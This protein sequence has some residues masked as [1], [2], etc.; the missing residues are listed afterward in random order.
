MDRINAYAKACGFGVPTGVDLPHEKAGL[1]PSRDWK[2]KRFGEAWTRGETLNASIWQGYVLV[3]P[4][5][6][7]RYLGALVNGGKLL[8]P[9]LVLDEEPT[10]QGILPWPTNTAGF[11]WKPWWTTVEGARPGRL[12][13][14][15][16]RIGGKTGTARWSS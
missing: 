16:A 8:K 4:L 6:V 9:S 2:K 10:V 13:R 3:S 7:A 5:Q 15:D 11:C 1:I 14:P 12:L